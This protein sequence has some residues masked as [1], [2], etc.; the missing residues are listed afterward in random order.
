MLNDFEQTLQRVAVIWQELTGCELSIWKPGSSLPVYIPPPVREWSE[1]ARAEHFA[2]L[3]SDGTEW[4]AARSRR[5]PPD[6][7]LASRDPGG[8]AAGVL[9]LLADLLNQLDEEQRANQQFSQELLISWNRLSFLIELARIAAQENEQPVIFTRLARAL[10][11][12]T[13]VQDIC[14]LLAQRDQVH[15][16][17]ASEN[18]PKNLEQLASYASSPDP[19]IF[20]Q[21]QT[22]LPSGLAR[23]LPQ[24]GSLVLLPI[25]MKGAAQ[26]LLVLIDYP[27]PELSA[28]DREMLL[29]ACEQIG[30]LLGSVL[31]REAQEASRRLDHELSIASQ[32]QGSLLPTQ[33]PSVP[34]LEFA[35]S[36]RPA[37]L[38]GGDFYDVQ[39]VKDGLA[40]MVGDVAGKGIPAAMLT[41]M[42]HATLKSEA[43]RHHQPADLLRSVN[44]LIYEELDRSDTFITAFLA[45][46]QTNPLRLSYASAGHTTT[47]LWRS[48]RGDVVQL[49]STGLPLGIN[50]HLQISQ[51]RMALEPGDVLMLY[52]DGVTEA[53]N[54]AGRV[55]GMQALIDLLMAAHAASADKQ[56]HLVL[57]TLDLHRGSLALND[58]VVLFLARA[59]LPPPL[60]VDVRPFVFIADKQSVRKLSSLARQLASQLTFPS[61]ASQVDYLSELELAVSEIVTNI[62]IHAYRDYPYTG[63]IQGCITI[64]PDRICLD[65]VD[66]GLNFQPQMED[67]V[68]LH[69]VEKDSQLFSALPVSMADHDPPASGY[70]L[71]IARRLL[72]I[73]QYQQLKGKRN[74]WRLEKLIHAP[75]DL[76]TGAAFDG[77]NNADSN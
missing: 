40:I 59:V 10:M 11:Q 62:V 61:V 31:I 29:N 64:W 42:I 76:Q 30:M 6:F 13:T 71:L 52:S 8:G 51:H 72:D 57:E 15:L 77:G 25:S 65:I 20:L 35:A 14:L 37:Y 44:R 43:Q 68:L 3:Q 39:P 67:G 66:H 2:C 55:L 48:A 58:D 7:F 33:L 54:E 32:I 56:L 69:P 18:P 47:L 36:L 70:G 75:S 60:P 9:G 41:A 19:V 23:D 24:V 46:L 38:I 1:Q 49:E 63:R 34:G 26:G 53:E 12:I 21:R 74:Y 28:R 73:C 45:V 22:N 27:H 17:A 4:L 5:T 50:S 16:Y